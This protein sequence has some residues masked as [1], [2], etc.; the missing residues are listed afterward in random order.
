MREQRSGYNPLFGDS[1]HT[2]DGIIVDDSDA[3]RQ[4]RPC[5]R[6]LGGRLRL[7]AVRDDVRQRDVRDADGAIAIIPA[8]S[9]THFDAR[10]LPGRNG[11]PDV[12]DE[13]RHGLE[14][15]VRMFP[16]DAEMYNQLGDDR[17]HTYFDLPTTDS[18]DYGWGKGKERPVYPCTGKPQG[19][20]QVQESLDGLRV[21]RRQ[22]RVGVR[23]RRAASARDATRPSPTRCADKRARRV[24][25]RQTLSRRLPDRA[26]PRALLLRRRQLGRRHGARRGGALRAHARPDVP[27][28]TRSAYARQ[29]PVTPWMGADTAR[30][31]QW[32][33]WHNN[34]HYEI[35]ARARSAAGQ[36]QMARLLSPT[37]SSAVV[38]ARRQRLPRRHSVHLVLERPDGVVRDAG[39]PLPPDDRRQALSRIRAG[40]ARLAV[41]HESVG[42][43]DGD[44]LAARRRLRRAIRT[45]SSR[46]ELGVASS[47]GGLLD[48]PVY[49]SIFQ[50]LKGIALTTPTSTR[51][52]TPASSSI[53]TTSA[54]TRPTSRSWTARRI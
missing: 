6:R 12:L 8:P 37:G 19:L 20:V 32:Y 40:G 39:D 2:H 18:S 17:D 13:A 33:P 28:A 46:S 36:R 5:E 42:N 53:T 10:G 43:V 4:V 21:H 23:A 52:S 51:H 1:V 34:G 41:R 31:Y 22:V 29:E 7:S 11:I 45:P 27:R 30:H 14:W 47:R 16:D 49:R 3:R 24:R 15:L 38:D 26:R 9:A 54:T 35:V 50:N 48:G 44:R 25:A